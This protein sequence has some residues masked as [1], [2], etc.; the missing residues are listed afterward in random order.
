MRVSEER[1]ASRSHEQR[2]DRVANRDH[3][4]VFVNRRAM[5]QLHTGITFKIHRPMRHGA[6]PLEI[7]R[8]EFLTG[9]LCCQGGNGI[10]ILEVHEAADGFV[11]VATD[12]SRPQGAGT[13]HHL[14]GTGAV[15]DEIAQVHD[16][17]VGGGRSQT[18][19]Q[20]FEIA[21]NIAD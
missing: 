14:V 2:L 15:A 3:V 18:S 10:E 13:F 4:I 1:D 20:R 9:P 12:E 5:H 16:D 8:C 6:Q 11:V 19:F 7:L 21:M 17:V